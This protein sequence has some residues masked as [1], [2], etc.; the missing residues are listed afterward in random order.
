MSWFTV[1]CNVLM[2]GANKS[3]GWFNFLNFSICIT[4]EG[5]WSELRTYRHQKL[6]VK[7]VVS[8]FA[9]LMLKIIFFDFF[10]RKISTNR[11]LRNHFSHNYRNNAVICN[12]RWPL[13]LW[14]IYENWWVSFSFSKEIYIAEQALKLSV[15]WFVERKKRILDTTEWSE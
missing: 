13:S 15:E 4:L 14:F 7:R 11:L 3:F 6:N 10:K 9:L 1:F 5:K 2:E 8:S 12:E